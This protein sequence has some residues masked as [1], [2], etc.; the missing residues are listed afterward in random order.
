MSSLLVFNRVYRLEIQ[1]VML[2]SFDPA[3]YYCHSNLLSDTMCNIKCIHIGMSC[4]HEG[5]DEE[6]NNGYIVFK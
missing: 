2:V 3:L 5:N 6:E 1:S 4:N